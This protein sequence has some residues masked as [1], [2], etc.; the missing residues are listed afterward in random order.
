RSQQEAPRAAQKARSAAILAEGV[1]WIAHAERAHPEAFTAFLE[2]EERGREAY[3][4]GL[5]GGKAREAMLQDY[6]RPE[7]RLLRFALHFTQY[8]P[9]GPDADPELSAWLEE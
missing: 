4:R 8:G 6:D 7:K 1:E 5:T 2:A 9:P 3:V